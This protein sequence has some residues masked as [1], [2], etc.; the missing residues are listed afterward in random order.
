MVMSQLGK[1]AEEEWSGDRSESEQ[2]VQKQTVWRLQ[3]T[4]RSQKWL[5]GCEGGVWSGILVGQSRRLPGPP[6]PASAGPLCPIPPRPGP[7]TGSGTG[8]RAE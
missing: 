7:E 6:Q 5:V 1:R 8:G 3:A 2:L 4:K